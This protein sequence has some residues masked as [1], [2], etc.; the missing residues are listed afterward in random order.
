MYMY[1]KVPQKRG[2]HVTISPTNQRPLRAKVFSF[3]CLKVSI[4]CREYLCSLGSSSLGS[5]DV[6]ACAEPVQTKDEH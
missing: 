1:L 5:E 6:I 3:E 4:H 2:V